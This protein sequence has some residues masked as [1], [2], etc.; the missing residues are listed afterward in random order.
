[1][2]VFNRRAQNLHRNELFG[3]NGKFIISFEQS[4]RDRTGVLYKRL[5]KGKM[6]LYYCF[7]GYALPISIYTPLDSDLEPGFIKITDDMFKQE[8]PVIPIT[9]KGEKRAKLRAVLPKS[10]HLANLNGVPVTAVFLGSDQYQINRRNEYFASNKGHAYAMLLHEFGLSDDEVRELFTAP[11]KDG[12]YQ[13]F[14]NDDPNLYAIA[15][16]QYDAAVDKFLNIISYIN[17]LSYGN[18]SGENDQAAVKAVAEFFGNSEEEVRSDFHAIYA[19]ET[20]DYSQ[21]TAE[22]LRTIRSKY[23]ILHNY[24]VDRII[25]AL[26]SY[27]SKQGSDKLSYFTQNLIY[28]TGVYSVRAQE[29]RHRGFRFSLKPDREFLNFYIIPSSSGSN[30][31]DVYWTQTSRAAVNKDLI[32]TIS[33]N[34]LFKN[35]TDFG[36]TLESIIQTLLNND[37]V[38]QTIRSINPDFTA[39]SIYDLIETNRAMFSLATAIPEADGGFRF[40]SPFEGDLITLLSNQDRELMVDGD[41]LDELIKTSNIFKYGIFRH[42]V[43]VSQIIPHQQLWSTGNVNINSLS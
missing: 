32:G 24:D 12:H 21:E 20:G 16:V 36:N 2:S 28:R 15:G 31:L 37:A 4:L 26:F 42:I 33:W 14:L 18:V 9:S 34:D 10:I 43:A 5:Y 38:A 7:D 11:E 13:Y 23:N 1:M 6:V 41:S 8:T 39:E 27:F 19:L 17:H 25:S 35:E 29:L 3:V 30:M 40:Y 22:R